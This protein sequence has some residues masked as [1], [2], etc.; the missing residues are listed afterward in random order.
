MRFSAAE[1][2]ILGDNSSGSSEILNAVVDHIIDRLQAQACRRAAVAQTVRF[3]D[4]LTDQYASMAIIACGGAQIKGILTDYLEANLQPAQLL[5]A[6]QSFRFDLGQMKERAVK[7]CRG[8]FRRKTTLATYSNSSMVRKVVSHYRGKIRS[9]CLS[10]SRPICEGKLA[11]DYF[12]GLGITVT[13]CVDMLLPTFF[14]EA[15]YFLIGADRVGHKYLTNKIGT[16]ALLALAGQVGV[17]RVVLFESM[18][19]MPGSGDLRDFPEHDRREVWKGKAGR[20]I[21]V[22]NRYFE[23]IPVNLVDLFISDLGVDSYKSL[24]RRMRTGHR[25]DVRF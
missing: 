15:D 6:L 3:I 23:V 13:Y 4:T 2:K 20:N 21:T 11:A 9:V 8:L 16:A 18:K 22:C 5:R 14:K 17:K 10:E 19:L 1:K 24:R 12:A 7:N 25:N